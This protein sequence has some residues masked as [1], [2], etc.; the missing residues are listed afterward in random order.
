[1]TVKTLFIKELR[2]CWKIGAWAAG[3]MLAAGIILLRM[4]SMNLWKFDHAHKTS[5]QFIMWETSAS[6]PGSLTGFAPLLMSMVILGTALAIRQFGIPF[7][8]GEWG[9]LLHRPIARRRIL[10]VKLGVAALLGLPPILI[11]T[12]C[13]LLAQVPGWYPA[14]APARILGLGMV[15]LAWSAVAY[16]AV[17]DGALLHHLKPWRWIKGAAVVTA[18]LA[19]S[20]C[21][22][23]RY[24]ETAFIQGGLL[25]LLLATIYGT[26]LTREF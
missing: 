14:P 17:A 11:W 18:I 25:L 5:W 1:M 22:D 19:F 15:L 21:M 2:E 6:H 8:T 23:A 20:S 7:H 9:F 12:A 3:I 26:F 13:W 10:S 4:N 24:V 16:C